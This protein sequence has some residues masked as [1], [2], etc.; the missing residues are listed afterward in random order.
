MEPEIN[1]SIIVFMWPYDNKNIK[2]KHTHCAEETLQS[3]T[4]ADTTVDANVADTFFVKSSAKSSG[5][6][7][8]GDFSKHPWSFFN[9]F[10]VYI[11]HDVGVSAVIGQ[12]ILRHQELCVHRHQGPVNQG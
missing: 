12:I 8:M 6:I 10:P 2:T 5:L 9:L 3:N 4:G 11:Y 1:G 7:S